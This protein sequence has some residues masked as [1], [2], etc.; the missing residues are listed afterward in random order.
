M[1]FD[2]DLVGRAGNSTCHVVS[3][4]IMYAMYAILGDILIS[5]GDILC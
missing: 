4:D 1:V 5:L 2:G 3:C